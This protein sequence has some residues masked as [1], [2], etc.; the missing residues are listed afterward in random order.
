MKILLQTHSLN[1]GKNC[2]IIVEIDFVTRF[3]NEIT[4]IEVKS[5]NGNSKS[6]N[7]ILTNKKYNVNSNFKLINGNI[8]NNNK[9]QTIPLYMAFLINED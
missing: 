7:E 6:L 4:V 3:N 8:G 1:L 5:T 9:I 2:I